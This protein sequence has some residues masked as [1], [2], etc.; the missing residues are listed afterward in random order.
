MSH[1]VAEQVYCGGVTRAADAR[2]AWRSLRQLAH[3]PETIARL[4]DRAEAEGLTPPMAKALMHLAEGQPDAMRGLAGALRCDTSYVTSLVDHLEAE[5]L[6]RREPH[7]SDRRV[8]VVA[9]TETGRQRASQ[10]TDAFD[11]P[12]PGFDC[13]SAA[14]TATLAGLL[15]RVQEG[16]K[17]SRRAKSA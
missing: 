1:R 6:A 5:G 8:K 12:P 3:D 9:L 10:V 14:E 2:A 13:L 17:T 16:G 15:A 4:R 11:E 7:P